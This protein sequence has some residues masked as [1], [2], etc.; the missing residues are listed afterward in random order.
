MRVQKNLIGRY[1]T[2]Y[3]PATFAT[4]NLKDETLIASHCE[5]LAPKDE[6]HGF[7]ALLLGWEHVNQEAS[8]LE[9]RA[10]NRIGSL[11]KNP[12]RSL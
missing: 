12:N 5:S 3:S 10:P 2:I 4:P 9:P 1:Y 7:F 11:G 6:E 8:N